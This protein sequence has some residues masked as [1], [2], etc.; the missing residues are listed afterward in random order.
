MHVDVSLTRKRERCGLTRERFEHLHRDKIVVNEAGKPEIL[1]C[2]ETDL[3]H[4]ILLTV[5]LTKAV[6]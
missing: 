2:I 3:Y 5:K 1:T 6:R 4:L